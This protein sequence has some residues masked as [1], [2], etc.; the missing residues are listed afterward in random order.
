MLQS[1]YAKKKIDFNLKI[2]DF[3]PTAEFYLFTWVYVTAGKTNS[4]QLQRLAENLLKSI[5]FLRK[6]ALQHYRF[7]IKLEVKLGLG[8]L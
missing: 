2:V 3:R 1:T 8:A 6:S 5:F 4:Q 7:N